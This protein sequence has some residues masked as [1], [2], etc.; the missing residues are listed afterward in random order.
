MPDDRRV[1]L[2]M[3]SSY[4]SDGQYPPADLVRFAGEAGLAAIAL[5]DHDEVSGLPEFMAAGKEKGIETVPGVE[6]TCDLGERWVHILGYF[7]DWEHEAITRA[8]DDLTAARIR[9]AAGRLGRLRELGIV[10]DEVKLADEARGQPPVGPVI[11]RV[12]LNDPVNDGHL[13]LEE[14]RQPPKATAPYFH[15]DRDLLS[16]GKP[17]YYPVER[18]SPAQAAAVMRA[19]GGVAV[20]AH[21]GDRFRLPQDEGIFVE[22]AAEG[23]GGIECYCSYHTEE[24]GEQFEELARRL[25]LVPTAGSDFHGPAVKPHVKMGDITH[26]PYSLVDELRERRPTEAAE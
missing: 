9:Q 18:M 6:F 23:L 4:S 17:A 13:L 10:V 8:I 25:G 2:H 26:N 19:A 7:I 22:L 20:F 5:T 24:Q 12:V 15:F 3:H 1:D 16:H 14:L 11:G 21:P